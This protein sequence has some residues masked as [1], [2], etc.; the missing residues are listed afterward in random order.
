MINW[1]I[2]PPGWAI[3]PLILAGLFLIWL[4]RARRQ[5]RVLANDTATA[6]QEVTPPRVVAK[7]TP[8]PAVAH[9]TQL[10]P[11]RSIP[12]SGTKAP[13]E[14]VRDIVEAHVTPEFLTGLFEGNTALRAEH[15]R[16]S[17]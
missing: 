8:A 15:L 12:R 14:P 3:M 10:G 11:K 13:Q 1:I 5:P 17:G 16:W 2:D 7:P 4:D 9:Y 6:L